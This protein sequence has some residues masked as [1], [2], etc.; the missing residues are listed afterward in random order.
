MSCRTRSG[1]SD[2]KIISHHRTG[3]GRRNQNLSIIVSPVQAYMMCLVE[4]GQAGRT[5]ENLI[6]ANPVQADI[7][8]TL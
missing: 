3:T 1:Q 6:I 7:V 2:A 4:L 8:S 5:N